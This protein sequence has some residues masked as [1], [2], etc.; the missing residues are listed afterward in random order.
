M[1]ILII[2]V[3]CVLIIVVGYFE[4]VRQRQKTKML[5]EA[6]RLIAYFKTEL[7]FH[8]SDLDTLY[9]G[10]IAHGFKCIHCPDGEFVPCGDF[11]QEVQIDLRQFLKSI[12]TSDTQG[13]LCLCDEY[14][15]RLKG[16]LE[17]QRANEKSK[18]QVTAALSL[19]GAVSV[20]VLFV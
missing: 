16:Y 17:E 8:Q 14:I 13:Q 4:T 3:S 6:I 7:N 1:K 11:S 19:L 20:V 15:H 2:C 10:A 12:G 5:D 18:I 9:R